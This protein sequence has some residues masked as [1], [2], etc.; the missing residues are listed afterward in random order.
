MTKV[1]AISDIALAV[2]SAAVM[3]RPLSEW[4]PILSEECQVYVFGENYIA[5]R[6]DQINYKFCEKFEAKDILIDNLYA[7]LRYKYFPKSTEEI[8]EKIN[9]IVANFTTN[10]KSTLKK[11]TLEED[12]TSEHVQMIP[13][14]CVAF[15][16]GVY[17]FR[18]NKWLLKYDITFIPIYPE[19]GE[20]EPV[21]GYIKD[22]NGRIQLRIH[23]NLS[24]TLMQVKT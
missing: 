9:R 20:Y 12:S 13:D 10:L 7:L 15:R 23:K 16:N 22:T 2:D 6:F 19:A 1:K 14:Y 17:N 24:K 8:D 18:D 21:L 11:I 4:R 5:K 3:D